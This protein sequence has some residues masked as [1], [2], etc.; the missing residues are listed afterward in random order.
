MHLTTLLRKASVSQK[1]HSTSSSKASKLSV[2][3]ITKVKHLVRKFEGLGRKQSPFNP[4]LDTF[5][6][7]YVRPSKS[8]DLLSAIAHLSTCA[9]TPNFGSDGS[10]DKP[11]IIIAH[12][13][14]LYYDSNAAI[15][16]PNIAGDLLK[17]TEEPIG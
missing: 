8:N 10:I 14:E 4:D 15:D 2:K 9:K 1:S 17:A 3:V 7:C 6:T 16:N 5:K 13:H 11:P 12:F